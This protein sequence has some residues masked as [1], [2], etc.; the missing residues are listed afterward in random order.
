MQNV[1]KLSNEERYELFRNTADKLGMNDAIIEKDF[2]VC[3]MLDYLFHRSQWKEFIAFKGGTSLSK[4]FHL[5]RRF[6]EDIDLI[7]NWQVLGYSKDEP[8]RKR[9]NTKQE[10]FNKEANLRVESFL[11]E[12]FCPILKADLSN[13]LNQEINVFIDEKDKQTII[14]AYPRLFKNNSIL[15]VIRL[16]IGALA[17]WTPS[18]D[19]Q[20][21]PYAAICYPKLF[22]QKETSV[23]TVTPER[24]FWEKAT[25]LHHEANRPDY[26]K[27]PTRYSRHYYDLYCMAL[28]TVKQKAFANLDLLKT[29]ID[30]KMK[31]YP[32]AWAKY[33]EAIPGTLKLLPPEYRMSDLSK[34]YQNMKD[35]I[36]GNVPTFDEIISVIKKLEEEI[37]ALK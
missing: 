8:W 37:N 33:S 23:L 12:Y 27:M 3:F 18:I 21:V 2:W 31:F 32:R 10:L 6:S 4:A 13:E 16:E 7:L 14:F 11:L 9:S 26:L 17:A 20:I 25:I 22:K 24:T 1:A 19:A 29:V 5:I 35:M 28:S 30:F 15:Q 36:Y 34:D